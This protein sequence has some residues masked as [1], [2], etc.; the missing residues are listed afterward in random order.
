MKKKSKKV[1]KRSLKPRGP[2]EF[3]SVGPL[4]VARFGKNVVWRADW[5][6]GEFALMQ[7]RLAASHDDVVRRIDES[8]RLIAELVAGL[9]PLKM[10]HRAWWE[11][12]AATLGVDNEFDVKSEH[13][14]ASRML[15]FVQ[16]VVAAVMPVGDV[17]EALPD[18]DWRK[19]QVEVEKLF[20]TLNRE[21][22][23]VATAKRKLENPQ[24]DMDFEEFQFKSQAYWANVTGERY[25]V[26]Q[27]QAL[28][29]L[30]VPQSAVIE[31]MYGLSAELL[32]NELEK[33]W[34]S[35]TF[36]VS[37]SFE[38][39]HTFRDKALAA[40]EADLTSGIAMVEGDPGEFLRQAVV[41]NGLQ[42]E[43]ERAVGLFIL[44]DLFDLQKITHLPETFLRDF[45]WAPGED[46]DFF[47]EGSFRGWPLRVWPTFK[48]PFLK[49]D[50]RYYCFDLSTLFDHF[51]R[52]FEK[53]VFVQQQELK[54]Q[55]ITKRKEVTETLP[56]KYLERILPGS[57]CIREAYY[58]IADGGSSKRFETDGLVIFDDHLFIIE[59]KAGAFT[60]TS[61]ATDVDAHVQSLKNLVSSPAEQGLRFLGYLKSA[62]EVPVFDA[63][64]NEI[65][66]LRFGDFRHVSVCA[67]TLDPF[68][69]LA[70]Q[71]QHL[72][73]VGV[74]VGA[75]AVW[76]MAID[77]LRVYADV[78][79][80]PFEFLHYVEQRK[81][82]FGSAVLQLDD[83]LDHLGLYFKHNHYAKHAAGL[84]TNRQAHLQFV[85]YRVD[86][87][88]YFGARLAKEVDVPY[89]RQDMPK[90]LT[91]VLDLLRRN[92]KAGAS[93]LASYLLDISG[94]WR[95]K[96]FDGVSSEVAAAA[97]KQPRPMSTHGEVRITIFP[98]STLASDRDESVAEDH[99][100]AL[101]LLNGESDRMLLELRYGDDGRLLDAEWRTLRRIDI[102]EDELPRLAGMAARLRAKR[103][104]KASSGGSKIGRNESCPCG[105][106]QKFKKCCLL[107]S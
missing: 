18:E 65:T 82:A 55:W 88:R 32:C 67:V 107:E 2:D 28:R 50:D 105:S 14:H 41:R 101:L 78:F 93:V 87:D 48:R 47:A 97:Q 92:V 15:D 71:I 45:A 44:Y 53:R 52:Q 38:A 102:T 76:S 4:N 80:N 94:E 6:E 62:E 79:L 1:T 60:Y 86:I 54:Q 100:K 27:V 11:R 83:E 99:A 104:E 25:Q 68:T 26:H 58:W 57:R 103:I 36:G 10:L 29:D 49:L 56:F 43:Q 70:A 85:G 21:Y 90:G 106:G 61:P 23:M 64:R 84:I 3:F 77:D 96:V 98:W 35:L 8:V 19:L 40:A 16:S 31:Q 17:K 72:R 22:F 81:E 91:E 59:V 46:K 74:D 63:A 37:D 42:E 34:Q 5:V 51:Y 69:E 12:S 24:L 66:R 75:T 7:Q 13:V 30:L 95:I 73:N 9:P 33:I 20:D 39:M 89:L